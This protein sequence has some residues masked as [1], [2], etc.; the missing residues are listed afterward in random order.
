MNNAIAP[1]EKLLM[2]EIWEETRLAYFKSK[3]NEDKVVEIVKKLNVIKKG[4][5]DCRWEK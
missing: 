5:E 1:I 4:I 3:G 2:A